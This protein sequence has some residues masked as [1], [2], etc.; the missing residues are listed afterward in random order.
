VYARRIVLLLCGL[1]ALTSMAGVASA[2][3]AANAAAGKPAPA[4]S[5]VFP[6]KIHRQTLDN[7]MKLVAVPYDSPGT[8]AFYVVMRTGS[9]DE[10]EAGH[11]GFAH[12]FEH[13]MFRGTE[14]YPK[15]AYTD[16]LKRM[17]AD[18]NAF[19]TDDETVFHMIAP[20]SQL[21]LI[22]DIESDRFKNL[23]YDQDAF[24][25]EALAVYGEYNKSVS[26]PVQP[27]FEKLHDVAFEKHTYKHTTLGFVADIKAMPNYYDYSIQFFNRFYRPENATLLVVGDVKPDNAFALAKQYFGDWKKGYKPADIPVEP[28]QTAKKTAS[29]DWPNPTHP[30]VMIGYHVPADSA[31]AVDS[32]A[33]D[34]LGELLF[35][36][37]APLFQDLVVKTQ[38]V[39]FVQ[40]GTSASRDPG[41]FTILARVKT[42]ELVPK[43]QETIGRY[44]HDLQTKPVD[45]KELDRIKSHQ[46]YAFELGLDTPGNTAAQ[47]AQA[48]AIYGDIDALNQ[49]FVAYQKVTPADIQRV[50]NKFF[51]PQNETVVTLAHKATAAAAPG[52]QGGARHD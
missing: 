12:F 27:M 4:A 20:A 5:E 44:I 19:T 40:G 42:D 34:L 21:P 7:G 47:A 2:A 1:L 23:K 31:T 52:T 6:F 11:S 18:S 45:A 14:K 50:A 8:I 37:S 48:I 51:Q 26:N 35:S 3:S 13:M 30:F 46:R 41:L 22:M 43:V 39:D 49:R 16:V 10:V 24:R 29:I 25:T 9:R 15:D 28:P 33:L 32:A 38:S 17:G 36:D